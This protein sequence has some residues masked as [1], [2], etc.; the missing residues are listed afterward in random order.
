LEP[1]EEIRA[2]HFSGGILVVSRRQRMHR[3]KPSR[4]T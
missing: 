2:E 4:F 1:A 3:R